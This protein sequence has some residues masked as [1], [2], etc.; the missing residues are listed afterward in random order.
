MGVLFPVLVLEEE[1]EEEAE[2]GVAFFFFRERS[3]LDSF[4]TLVASPSRP[5]KTVA[6]LAS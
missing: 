3:C 2:A 4:M 5:E 1:E 6:N